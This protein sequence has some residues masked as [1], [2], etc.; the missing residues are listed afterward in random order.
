MIKTRSSSSS[1]FCDLWMKGF[2]NCCV[3][4]HRRLWRQTQTQALMQAEELLL[5]LKGTKQSNKKKK[6]PPS[7]TSLYMWAANQWSKNS[8]LNSILPNLP[9]GASGLLGRFGLLWS[10]LWNFQK[11]RNEKLPFYDG[12]GD[13]HQKNEPRDRVHPEVH[14]M[15]RHVVQKDEKRSKSIL[16][17]EW[18]PE[19][20]AAG[21]EMSVRSL[22]GRGCHESKAVCVS[23]K[24]FCW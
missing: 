17:E 8:K 7:V 23:V 12:D 10:R 20:A 3:I 18:K 4:T 21:K 1:L 16:K 24:V 14:G 9:G 6:A 11:L 5:K 13:V 15:M 22:S 19:S 2:P